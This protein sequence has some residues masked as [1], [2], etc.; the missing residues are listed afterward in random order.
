MFLAGCLHVGDSAGKSVLRKAPKASPHW[1]RVN[2]IIARDDHPL[3]SIGHHSMAALP[4]HA[5]AQFLENPKQ[6]SETLFPL[7]KPPQRVPLL[8]PLLGHLANATAAS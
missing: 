8:A 5:E 6:Q 4:R 1:Q 7:P 3:G 2:S